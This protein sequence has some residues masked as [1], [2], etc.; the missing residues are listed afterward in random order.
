M[1]QLRQF[2]I[3]GFQKDLL[4]W[5][6]TNKR[7]LPWRKTNDPYHIWISE[8]MLQQ[9]QVITVI[10]YY[11]KFLKKFPTV[12]HLAE[13]DEQTVLK[14]WEGLGYYSRARYLHEAAKEVVEHYS[15]VIPSNKKQLSSL[16]GIGPYTSGAILSIA[17]NQPEPAVDGNVMR[18]LSR[19]LLI[20]D[21]IAEVRTR[22]KFETTVSMIISKEDPSSFNQGLMELG[23]MVCTPKNPLCL[24]CPVRDHCRAFQAGVQTELP[25]K[26]R[27]KRQKVEPYIVVIIRKDDEVLIEQRPYQGLL[28][29]M[30]Q[31]P[32]VKVSAIGINEVEN[33]VYDTYGISAKLGDMLGEVKHIFTHKIWELTIYEM[34][35]KN[36]EES[37]YNFKQ[38]LEASPVYEDKIKVKQTLAP[39]NIRFEQ[40]NKLSTYPSSV[41]HLKIKSLIK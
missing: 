29:N 19:I 16:K 26:T 36:N 17:F 4:H 8:I 31:F 41:S 34:S 38:I 10:P 32:M 39:Q 37:E 3:N 27:A 30:W 12:Y 13:A 6:L 33:W 40:I 25:V 28:A 23:A 15:G 22:K 5:Y 1:K 11:E 18:V 7:E 35:V 14:Q 21:N 24:H 20:D 2:N 9:T